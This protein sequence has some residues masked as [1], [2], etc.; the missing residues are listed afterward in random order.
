[1]NITR[2][3]FLR[4]PPYF[5]YVKH[6]PHDITI[7]FSTAYAASVIKET[8]REVNVV[9]VWANNWTLGQV[10]RHISNFRPEV[11]FFDSHTSVVPILEE[12]NL[13]IKKQFSV[14]TIIFGAVSTFFPEV[15][16]NGSSL[17][18]IGIVGECE[19]TVVELVNALD[20]N[21]SLE[22]IAGLVYWQTEKS[23]IIKTAE[24]PLC[25]DL[26]N[27]PFIDYRLFNL[28]HYRK[29]SFPIPLYKPVKWG[30]IP[31]YARVSLYLRILQL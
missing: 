18:D 26:D 31:F 1:M 16:F 14:K 30:H 21:R 22:D 29:Y 5:G 12:V 20:K 11:I 4:L 28:K 15:I 17:F 24:R 7:P 10:L 2:T 3:L 23:Q 19:E 6:H 25:K 9:D 8:G 27:L 13:A